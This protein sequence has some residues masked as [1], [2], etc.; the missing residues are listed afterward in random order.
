MLSFSL[1]PSITSLPPLFTD[2][3][4]Q[5][6]FSGSELTVLA[7][8]PVFS[9]AVASLTLP[10]LY[11]RFSDRRL[12]VVALVV[13][14]VSLVLRG[15][16]TGWLLPFTAVSALAIG[17]IGAMIPGLIKW[18][19]PAWSG[20]LLAAYLVG[21]YGGAMAGSAASVPIYTRSHGS[22]TLA[23][24]IWAVAAMAA[25]PVCLRRLRRA[26][27]GAETER[28]SGRKL[29]RAQMAW[30][31]IIF[32][33]VQSL[34]YYATLSWLPTLLQ[35][36]GQSA[37]S[38]GFVAAML[39]IGGLIA[40]WVIPLLAARFAGQ[41]LLVGAVVL[42]T[43]AGLFGLAFL[44]VSMAVGWSVVLGA[45]QGG[46]IG[47][48]LYFAIA[49]T[50]TP[51]GAATLSSLSQGIGYLIAATGPPLME[52]WHGLTG[53]WP[54]AFALLS[55]VSVIELG[56]GLLAASPRRINV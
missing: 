23:L 7:T 48:A 2:L 34:I 41:R 47:L 4:N 32:M 52:W 37:E 38:S 45:G 28:T 26:P 22:M 19:K 3:T 30:F 8:I 40:A 18:Y 25:V 27:R 54:A 6:N 43:I 17:I 10:L 20:P 21:L 49:R 53:S 13:L 1:R 44:P 56:A 39:N 35:A 15:V 33:A 11:R 9:F 14:G 12:V 24:S 46:A 5:L 51:A 16:L 31:V 36:R 42:A 50:T 55:V 29:V